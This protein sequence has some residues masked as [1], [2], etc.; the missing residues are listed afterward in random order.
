MTHDELEI[1]FRKRLLVTIKESKS[2]PDLKGGTYVITAFGTWYNEIMKTFEDF[3]R[4]KDPN[5]Q[6][7]IYE[8]D[9]NLI[10]PMPG[11][12]LI[13]QKIMADRTTAMAVQCANL[14]QQIV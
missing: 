9:A 8:L 1:A 2:L 13:I 11:V 10:E 14:A 5:N 4:V 12:E 7:T 6:R 3:V